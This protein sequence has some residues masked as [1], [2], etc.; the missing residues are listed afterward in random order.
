MTETPAETRTTANNHTVVVTATNNVAQPVHKPAVTVV[1][2]K[3]LAVGVVTPIAAVSQTA[4]GDTAPAVL[5][6]NSSSSS[7]DKAGA[8]AATA[9]A[10]ATVAAVADDAAEA[11]EQE[12]EYVSGAGVKR[13]AYKFI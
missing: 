4:Q 3:P 6:T 7:N 5:Q 1:N 9:V 8:A 11:D 10:A 12:D 2:S 13:D